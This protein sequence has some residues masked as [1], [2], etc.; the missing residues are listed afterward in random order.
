VTKARYRSTFPDL[1]RTYAE[2]GATD[3]E[4]AEMFGV[5][6]RTVHRWKHSHPEFAAA[7]AV[8]KEV[9]DQRVEQSLYRRALGYT[10]DAVKIFMPAGATEPIIVPYVEHVPPDTV[11]AIFWLKNRKPD[12][13]REKQEVKLTSDNDLVAAIEAGRRRVD[14]QHTQAPLGPPPLLEF[15]PM[16]PEPQILD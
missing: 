2:Q 13:W 7:L 6:E 12:Q 16:R 10:H 15:R 11:A 9:A 14:E 5:S 8:G 1:A 3:R 4:V